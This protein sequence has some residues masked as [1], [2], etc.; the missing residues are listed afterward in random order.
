MNQEQATEL[1]KSELNKKETRSAQF[2]SDKTG[3]SILQVYKVL[4]ALVD[5]GVAQLH[6]IDEIKHYSIS[7]K[8]VKVQ[9]EPETKPSK[10]VI[11]PSGRDTTK[12]TID[13]N[14]QPY[15]KGQ[16]AYHVVHMHIEKT[17]PTLAQLRIDFPDTI[18]GRFC[19]FKKIEEA[20]ALSTDRPRYN[21]KDHQVLTTSDN[22]AVVV[23]NQWT[24]ERF[25]LFITAAK[26][27]G[28]DIRP[29]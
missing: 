2:L 29:E 26:Q 10:L 19:V 7:S 5:S 28:I 15:S 17:K 27:F 9:A 3:V 24:V 4:K 20:R 12:F 18:V 1:V 14:K 6:M 23:T 22:V 8:G 13:K 25:N 21:M 16:C 11:K